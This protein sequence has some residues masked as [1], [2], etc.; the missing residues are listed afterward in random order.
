M[1][2]DGPIVQKREDEQ[3]AWMEHVSRHTAV[4][5]CDDAGDPG[6]PAR[7]VLRFVNVVRVEVGRPRRGA[8]EH[9]AEVVFVRQPE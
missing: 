2:A 1:R 6:G 8:T 4:P 7:H 5:D 3:A 9:V